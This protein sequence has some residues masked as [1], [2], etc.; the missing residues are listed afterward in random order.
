MADDLHDVARYLNDVRI[1]FIALTLMGYVILI[2][3]GI[4]FCVRRNRRQRASDNANSR[5]R[6]RW[7]FQVEGLI[8]C[9]KCSLIIIIT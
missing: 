8:I 7:D 2:F 9:R 5:T 1:C 6:A 4:I 3:Y